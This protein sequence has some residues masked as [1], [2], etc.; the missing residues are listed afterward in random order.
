VS[1]QGT[2]RKKAQGLLWRLLKPC[3]ARLRRVEPEEE[4]ATSE[5]EEPEEDFTRDH[6]GASQEEPPDAE[7]NA[8][9]QHEEEVLEAVLPCVPEKCRGL[10]EAAVKQVIAN[11]T[12]GACNFPYATLRPVCE[13]LRGLT[14]QFSIIAIFPFDAVELVRR[15]VRAPAEFLRSATSHAQL[16]ELCPEVYAVLRAVLFGSSPSSSVLQDLVIDFLGGLCDAVELWAACS[17]PPPTFVDIPGSNNV[18][19]NGAAFQFSRSRTQGRITRRYVSNKEARAECNKHFGSSRGRSG[20]LFSF[21]CLLHSMC[22]GTAIINEAE[23][24]RDPFFAVYLYCR[25]APLT[26]AFDFACGLCEYALNREPFFWRTCRW[27]KSSRRGGG[28]VGT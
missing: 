14:T 25:E 16:R 6:S 7:I 8:V 22:I 15:L 18:E 27:G 23:G 12:G 28:G 13:L 3:A 1:Q 5:D 26:L 21:F 24:R 10:V 20:G 17:V 11:K 4:G 9:S 2:N 19:S